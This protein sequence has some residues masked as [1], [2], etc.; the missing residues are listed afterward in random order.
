MQLLV[1]VTVSLPISLSHPVY[2]LLCPQ[3]AAPQSSEASSSAADAEKKQGC[4]GQHIGV[5]SRGELFRER[6]APQFRDCEALFSSPLK[7]CMSA[8]RRPLATFVKCPASCPLPGKINTETGFRSLPLIP[9]HLRRRGGMCTSTHRHT[10]SLPWTL[11]YG[12]SLGRYV[13]AVGSLLG[14][15]SLFPV[16]D[17]SHH[18]PDP[19]SS[20][21][22]AFLTLGLA[23]SHSRASLS[24][25]TSQI[26]A[27][28]GIFLIIFSEIR[29][30]LVRTRKPERGAAY[31]ALSQR[32]CRRL[33]RS[34][35][36]PACRLCAPK[37]R[38][39][40][41]WT[42]ALPHR[43]QRRGRGRRRLQ[44]RA[45]MHHHD[46]HHHHHRHHAHSSP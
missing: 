23:S 6:S 32:R 13:Y 18:Q 3:P 8:R 7:L 33:T 11:S 28:I 14:S 25:P 46:L 1:L 36:L 38:V 40:P 4:R 22:D 24:L 29:M 43:A 44:V 34:T 37:M 20:L 31:P 19:N 16:R 42:S 5:A 12:S 26:L 9:H 45:C 35:S 41:W 10:G 2:P 17:C 21:L 39:R 30:V 27:T 15:A